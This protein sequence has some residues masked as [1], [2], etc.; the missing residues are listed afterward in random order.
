MAVVFC[1][2]TPP[3]QK[4]SSGNTLVNTAMVV[5]SNGG[6]GGATLSGYN[7]TVTQSATAVEGVMYNLNKYN[8]QYC[9]IGFK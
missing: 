6:T 5:K 3:T 9:A 8:G 2:D 1:K 7:L 4:D